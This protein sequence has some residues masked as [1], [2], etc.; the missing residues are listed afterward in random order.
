MH[1]ISIEATNGNIAEW[2]RLRFAANNPGVIGA[3]AM[4]RLAEVTKEHDLMDVS[5]QIQRVMPPVAEIQ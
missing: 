2:D 3:T 1:A 5:E 4:N